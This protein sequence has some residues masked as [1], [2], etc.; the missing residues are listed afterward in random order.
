MG[1]YHRG[2]RAVASGVHRLRLTIERLRP[3]A[4]RALL[5]IALGAGLVT[6]GRSDTLHRELLDVLEAAKSVIQAHPVGGP[7][8]FIGLAA[9]SAM[10]GFVSS[11]VLVPAAVYAWGAPLTMLMLWIGWTLGGV[12]AYSLALA[13]G[14]PF[15][16]WVV[17]G[18]ALRRYEHL[19]DKRPAFTSVLLFQ[20][21]LPSEIPGYLLG[22][23]RYPLSRYLA[24]LMLA[25]LPYAVGTVLLGVGF[26]ERDTA[27]LLAVCL[28][29]AVSL[30][31]IAQVLRKRHGA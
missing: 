13:F 7:L 21:A 30:A 15:L 19:L 28:I 1:R 2:Q 26:V 8:A 17:A 10:L 18:P 24:A 9:L 4:A 5:L 22:L 6:L 23:A 12:T 27:T 29:G 20:L 14:R 25:E 31:V 11:A 16:Q 3:L